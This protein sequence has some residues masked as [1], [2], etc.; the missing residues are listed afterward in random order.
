M[1]IKKNKFKEHIANKKKQIGIWSCLSNNTIAEIIS[2][3]GFDWSVIDMEHSPNDIQE[4][5]TQLQV[6]EGYDTEPVVRVPWNEPIMV[7]RI[8]DMGAQT[9]LFPFV[10]NAEE[11]KAAVAATRYPPKGIRGIMSAARMNRYGHVENYYE[12]AEKEICVIVQCETKDAIKNIP[13]ISKIDG[14]DGIFMGPS[15]ISGSIGKIGKFEDQEVQ[16][17]IHEAL[18]V[19]NK[20]G[21]P[22]GILTAKKDY[23][24]KY[25]EAGYTFVAINSDTNLFARSADSLLKEFK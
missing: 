24:K 11:A 21:K 25:V 23:A 9:I 12:D 6:M 19:C 8:L 1:K 20:V 5:L 22:A 16:D 17:L 2:V 14:V 10:Q 3:T 13:E 4:V 18:D 15:D 7:K